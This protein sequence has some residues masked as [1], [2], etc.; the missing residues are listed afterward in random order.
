M[1]KP[2]YLLML[3]AVSAATCLP[4]GRIIRTVPVPQ[5]SYF[6]PNVLSAL[7]ELVVQRERTRRNHF[8]V[9]RVKVFENGYSSVLVYWKENR[10]LI[11]WEPGRGNDLRGNPDARYD[12]RDSRRYWRLNR[13]VVPTLNDV[14]GSSFLI[15]RKDARTWIQECVHRGELYVVNRQA[16]SNKAL[17]LTAR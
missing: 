5:H 8:Y 15:T 7:K 1:R 4:Q 9:G 2:L 3:V 11:L 6:G 17:Q 10:A 14:Q 16:R 12:L 13:D